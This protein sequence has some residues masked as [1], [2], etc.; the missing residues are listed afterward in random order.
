M[1]LTQEVKE[2]PISQFLM[3]PMHHLTSQTSTVMAWTLSTV[4]ASSNPTQIDSRQTIPAFAMTFPCRI[5]I[6][7]VIRMNMG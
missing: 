2:L 5:M 4:L 1:A 6:T 7:T 3:I